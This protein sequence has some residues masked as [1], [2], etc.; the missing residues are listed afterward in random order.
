MKLKDDETEILNIGTPEIKSAKK[1]Y[2]KKDSGIP[3]E[4]SLYLRHLYRL[5]PFLHTIPA[6]PELKASIYEKIISLSAQEEK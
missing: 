4:T 5:R 6:D 1:Y 2:E 3:D